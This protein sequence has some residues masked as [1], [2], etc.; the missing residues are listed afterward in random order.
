MV[1]FAISLLLDRVGIDFILFKFFIPLR[2]VSEPCPECG[3]GLEAE[4]ALQRG[5]VGVRHRHVPGLHRD[6]LPVRLEV[7]VLRKHPCPDKLLLIIGITI[8][9][10]M[11]GSMTDFI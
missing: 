10:I 3:G 11:H 6:K 4:V 7:V 1:F 8:R 9:K 2:E 5:G